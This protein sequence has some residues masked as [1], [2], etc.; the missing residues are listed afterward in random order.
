LR[1]KISKR[2]GGLYCQKN[3]LT[4]EDEE[5]A[6]KNQNPP[7]RRGENQSQ[8]LTREGAERPQGRQAEF[9][10]VRHQVFEPF[11]QNLGL[12]FIVMLV[13]IVRGSDLD[14]LRSPR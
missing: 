11:L 14:F 10:L 8:R 13:F 6:K 3:N 7:R 2:A 12:I 9:D 4:E 5:G 1:E